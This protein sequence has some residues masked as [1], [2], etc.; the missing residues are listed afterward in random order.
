MLATYEKAL[1][2]LYTPEINKLLIELRQYKQRINRYLDKHA[3]SAA[4]KD[5]EEKAKAISTA[6]SCRIDG[7]SVPEKRLKE[8]MDGATEPKN[9][10]DREIASYRFTLN[11]IDDSFPYI[12][13]STGAILQLHRDLYRYIDVPF[14]GRWEDAGKAMVRESELGKLNTRLVSNVF[15]TKQ[16]LLRDACMNY[17]EAIARKA[18]DPLVA[19]CVF[20]L[21]LINIHPFAEANGRLSRLMTLL[22]MYQNDYFVGSY[23]SLERQIE[24]TKPA[25]V[26]AIEAGAR[27]VP[28]GRTEEDAETDYERFVL[29]LLDAMLACCKEFEAN[30]ELGSYVA[31]QPVIAKPAPELSPQQKAQ[32]KADA[33]RAERLRQRE[34]MKAQA[35]QALSNPPRMSEAGQSLL[36]AKEEKVSKAKHANGLFMPYPDDIAKAQAAQPRID[37]TPKAATS[38][39]AVPAPQATRAAAGGTNEDVVRAFFANLEGSASKREIA[40]ACPSMSSKTVERIIQRLLAEGSVVKEGAAR[41]TVYRRA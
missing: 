26:Q 39:K 5:E 18:C 2:Q 34:V 1:R 12:R 28:E 33:D 17:K 35:A 10:K 23:C 13:I 29:Y 24:L 38:P 8:L 36:A 40:A 14:A 21:D 30:H 37:S 20:A 22:M 32:K 16:T 31:E 27:I 15:I 41:S 4:M 6:A 11:T 19:I 3:K 25:Y 9:R 7:V